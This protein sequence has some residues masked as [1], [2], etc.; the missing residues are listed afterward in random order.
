MKSPRYI[1]QKG[2]TLDHHPITPGSVVRGNYSTIEYYVEFSME[3]HDDTGWSIQAR[4]MKN[5]LSTA[6]FNYLGERVGDEIEINDE[7]RKDDKLLVIKDHKPRP[8]QS[9]GQMQFNF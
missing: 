7:R 2:R 1:W 9:K 3:S 8:V 5:H 4:D 6:W